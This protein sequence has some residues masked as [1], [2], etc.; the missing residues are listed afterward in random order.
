M[1]ASNNMNTSAPW[2]R[3]VTLAG[4]VAAFAASCLYVF[5]ISQSCVR[6]IKLRRLK[7][8]NSMNSERNSDSGSR[9]IQIILMESLQN[10]ILSPLRGQTSRGSDH[11]N[12]VPGKCPNQPPAY[13][14]IY[15][16]N[17]TCAI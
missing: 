3:D 15:G 5:A 7:K 13:S 8:R 10:G 1:S 9:P 14:E 17:A 16:V 4:S 2:S 11:S 6:N 12:D